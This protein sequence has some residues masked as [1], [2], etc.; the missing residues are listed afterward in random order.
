MVG[1]G[2]NLKLLPEPCWTAIAFARPDIGDAPWLSLIFT[3]VKIF[4]VIEVAV[5]VLLIVLRLIV[6]LIG[7]G[8]EL[9]CR[10]ELLCKMRRFEVM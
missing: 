2:L 7:R 10:G 3:E 4:D 8:G 5:S 1:L 6:V 9:L